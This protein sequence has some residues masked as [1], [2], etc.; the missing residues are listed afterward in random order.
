MLDKRSSEAEIT[1][2]VLQVL[3][4]SPN[5]ELTTSQI[6]KRVPKY[7]NLTDGDLVG[8]ETRQHEAVWEQIVRNIVSHKTTEGNAIAE[9]LL[10]IP[11]RG[12]MRITEAGRLHVRNKFG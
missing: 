1:E 10:N 8:S 5:G 9:G 11:S 7:I 2:A 12:K 4:S 6:V 3:A